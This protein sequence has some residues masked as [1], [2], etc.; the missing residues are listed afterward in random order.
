M[1]S[2]VD[3]RPRFDE[4]PNHF[5]IWIVGGSKNEG[6]GAESIA[7]TYLCAS[8]D[9][10]SCDIRIRILLRSVHQRREP[11]AVLRFHAGPFITIFE[12]GIEMT[13]RLPVVLYVVVM[14]AVIVGVDLLFF[15]YRIWERLLGNI[16]IVLV[17]AAFY[18]RFLKKR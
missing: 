5:R 12:L 4:R 7:V 2:L 18:F 11:S 1:V 6:R 17:F 3:A 10:G 14:V 15:R 16:G 8:T 13:I 9:Q